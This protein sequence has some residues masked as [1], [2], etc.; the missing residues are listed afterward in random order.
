MVLVLHGTNGVSEH[1]E[2]L[3]AYYGFLLP[4]DERGDAGD[5]GPGSLLLS[6][7]ETRKIAAALYRL[8]HCIGIKSGVHP[9]LPKHLGTADVEPVREICGKK[10]LV[11]GIEFALLPGK[12]GGHE[13]GPGIGEEWAVGKGYSQRRAHGS[14]MSHDPVDVLLAEPRCHGDPLGR[15]I[16]MDLHSQPL[17]LE[18]ELLF[19]FF[20]DAF[21]DVAEGSDVVG[22]DS[23][24]D[25]HGILLAKKR[26]SDRLII[27]LHMIRAI[28]ACCDSQKYPASCI[29]YRA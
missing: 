1:V 7:L 15:S 13:S 3:G 11:K 8:F 22:K 16:R 4:D 19:Q 26:L 14:K 12:L 20:D 18:I 28:L 6:L 17:D 10:R 5:S 9:E 2:G 29:L 27:P 21:A 24:G 25:R 23:N